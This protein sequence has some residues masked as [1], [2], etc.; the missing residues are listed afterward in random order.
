MMEMGL[1]VNLTISA[2]LIIARLILARLIVAR[3]SQGI[4]EAFYLMDRPI[5]L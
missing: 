4:H 3:F 1:T 5:S 2:R